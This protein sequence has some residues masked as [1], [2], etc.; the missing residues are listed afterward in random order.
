M[1]TE[2]QVQTLV[3]KLEEGAWKIW[4]RRALTAMFVL[5]IV[6][7]WMF[8]KNGFKGLSH[9]RSIEQA[10]IARELNRGNGFSTKTIYP[11]ALYQFAGHKVE[12]NLG[13]IPD[14]YHAPLNPMINAIAFRISD[15][16]NKLFKAAQKK[17][18]WWHHPIAWFDLAYEPQMTIK[19]RIYVYDRIVVCM[20]F[21]FMV[22]GWL[23]S[24]FTM[25]RLFDK[26]LAVLGVWLLILCQSY[27]DYA[28]SGLPQ[29]LMF[30]LF[31][32]AAYCLMR[33]VENRVENLPAWRW[34]LACGISLGLLALTH[35][36][37]LWIA[38]GAIVFAIIYFPPRWLSAGIIAAAVLLIYAPWLA[39]NAR[40]C[41]NPLGLGWY[42]G[43]AEIKG[44]E[45]QIMRSME[46]PFERVSPAVFRNKV[47]SKVIG[48]I[49]RITEHLGYIVVAPVFFLALMHLFKRP[50]TSAFRWAILVMWLFAV[51]GMCVYGLE[52]KSLFMP[53][54]PPAESNDLHLLFIP[55]FV[56]YGLAFVLVMW[57]RLEID[58]VLVR[59]GFI[60]LIFILSST[61]FL[62]TFISLN[63]EGNAFVQWPPY[64]P[65][66]IALLRD[67]TTERE[68]I[69]SDMPWAVGWYADRKSLWLPMTIKEFIE[70]NDYNQLDG[71]IVGLYLTP[72]TGSRLFFPE[73]VKGE[74]KEW[75][76]FITRQVSGPSLRDFPLRAVTAMPIDN[77]CLFYADRDRW[78]TVED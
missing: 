6:Y 5:F 68:I 71:R 47:Q 67:W 4:V 23:V 35:G 72:M 22:A 2:T 27:W 41:G 1:A 39:R 7:L 76:P 66:F 36:V 37:A 9:Q 40:A 8:G 50:A 49:A 17:T 19:D 55:L 32:A 53:N 65:P 33:A 44:S 10:Q 42:A 56:A 61:R 3:H 16:V 15:W 59:Y 38:A 64:A 73:I 20:Q 46:P 63:K 77:E 29:N 69:A 52:G 70:L 78:S 13:R 21:L 31:S 45:S 48:Q 11:A 58:V 62:T 18:S 25:K 24:Y 28:L 51:A 43:L 26:R 57:S 74:F 12:L 30:F 75:A 14:A 60:V 54:A 34:L